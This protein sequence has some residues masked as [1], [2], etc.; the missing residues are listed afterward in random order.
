MRP[1]AAHV[2]V[3]VGIIFSIKAK[4]EKEGS[5]WV[6]RAVFFRPSHGIIALKRAV[7]KMR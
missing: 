6:M 4:I 7:R 1:K 3:A 5:Y 2:D